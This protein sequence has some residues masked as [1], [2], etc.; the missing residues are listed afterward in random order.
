MWL[1]WVD[2]EVF[3]LSFSLLLFVVAMDLA[4]DWWRRWWV[5]AVTGGAENNWDEKERDR[6]ERRKNKK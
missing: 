4:G 2:V 3:L 6:G 5:Y 1:W